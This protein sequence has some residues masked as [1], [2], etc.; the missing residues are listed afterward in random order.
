V[1]LAGILLEIL[2]EA[3]PSDEAVAEGDGGAG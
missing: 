1:L 3:E 2:S